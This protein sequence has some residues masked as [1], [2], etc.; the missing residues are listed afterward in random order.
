M[1][2]SIVGGS[3]QRAQNFKISGVWSS[4]C[5]NAGWVEV[6]LASVWLVLLQG[7]GEAGAGR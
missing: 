3:D 5:G 6:W 1:G 2:S 4:A 7:R